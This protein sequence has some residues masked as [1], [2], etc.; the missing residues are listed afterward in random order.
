M[1]VLRFMCAVAVSLWFLASPTVAHADPI[2]ISSGRISGHPS[3]SQLAM[4]VE[5]PELSVVSTPIGGFLAN[6]GSCTPCVDGGFV[7]T[8]LVDLGATLNSAGFS[9]GAI[10]GVIEGITYPLT[11]VAFSSGTITTPAVTLTELGRSLVDVPF[12]FTAV[13]NGFLESPVTRPSNAPPIF[14]VEL[15]GSGRASAS[16]IGLADEV[17][18]TGRSF[19]LGSDIEYDF[20]QAQPV[21]EPGTLF[22]VGGAIGAL[23]ARRS[24]R[25]K[26]ARVGVSIPEACASFVRKS[27]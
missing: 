2:V 3:A 13:M 11:F 8:P 15:T 21:P 16:F 1:P 26:S 23:A 12:S 20:V 19:S 14:T 18:P 7:P 22:L 10:M 27:W 4:G 24:I 6:I 17:S 9:E 5:G 25:A